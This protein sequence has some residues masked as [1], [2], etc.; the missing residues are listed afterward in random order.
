[1]DGGKAKMQT[2][3]TDK[4][5]F[6]KRKLQEYRKSGLGRR[7]FSERHGVTKSTMDYWFARIRKGKK[8][9]AMVE[10]KPTSILIQGSSLQVLVADKYRIEIHSGFDPILL[11]EVEESR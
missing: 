11:G 6:W 4:L 10:V 3:K 1:M 7:A 5:T 9:K 2:D 8:A